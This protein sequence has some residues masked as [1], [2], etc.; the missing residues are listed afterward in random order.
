MFLKNARI[1]VRMAVGFGLFMVLLVVISVACAL[2][3]RVVQ[4]H[5]QH[6]LEYNAVKSFI[7]AKEIDHLNWMAAI[8]ELFLQEEVTTLQVETDD[9][10]CGF[11][12][13]LYSDETQAMIKRGG[14]EAEIIGAILEPHRR[15]HDSAVAI[16]SRYTAYD[17]EL[18]HLLPE[19]WID[20]LNWVKDLSSSL[21]TGHAFGG[22]LDPRQCAFGAW[23][24][25]YQAADPELARLLKT[26]EEPH[27]RLHGSA[28]KVMDAMARGDQ[29]EARRIY[30]AE[31]LGALKELAERYGQTKAWM[32]ARAAGQNEAK[33]IFATRTIA[34]YGEI[35][36]L[37]TQLRNLEDEVIAAADVNLKAVIGRINLATGVLSL[38]GII[39]GLLGAFFITRAITRPLHEAIGGLSRGSD[40]VNKAS[41]QIATSSQVLA[42][43]TSQQAAALEET[44]ASIEEMAAMTKQ[45]ADNAAEAERHMKDADKVIGEAGLAMEE[46][47]RSM[48]DIAKAGADTQ[49]IVKTIDEIAFQTNLLALN[50]AVE[51]AR[52]GEAGAGFAVVADEVRNLA[53]RAAQAA[54]NTADLI[55]ETVG[56]T[57]AG[58]ALVDRTNQAF[59]QVT[60][61][62]GRISTL[63]SEISSASVEQAT[64]I[65]EINRAIAEMDKVVQQIAASAEESASAAEELHN[66]CRRSQHHVGDLAVIIHGDGAH[67]MGRGAIELK[68]ARAASRHVLPGKTAP[69]PPAKAL[70]AA[71][72]DG[73]FD[74]F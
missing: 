38:V 64:G 71:A 1:G 18:A 37:L 50:A 59:A 39:S 52:A 68:D 6:L 45:N 49:K 72:D 4:G 22:G 33:E 69:R 35:K 10:K 53:M 32:T 21:L 65:S 20:H 23:Y 61:T 41:T 19:R 29:A 63:V 27:A 54:R 5:A 48:A 47:I 3:L 9:H 11:G 12:Q 51:A 56:K 55:E 40:E 57:A 46:L 36:V 67:R 7:L 16:G 28:R 14:A 31:T 2:G 66:Q 42:E 73:E 15:L 70:A 30:N 43:G 58:S 44:S 74:D 25:G 24:H 13:W 26:W 34:A 17:S 62:T 8:N 60:G